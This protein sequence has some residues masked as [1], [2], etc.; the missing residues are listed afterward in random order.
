VAA[1]AAGSEPLVALIL[2]RP[3]ELGAAEQRTLQRA[4]VVAA[5]LLLRHRSVSDAEHRVR[6]ELLEEV[7]DAP[8]GDPESLRQRVRRF[9][10]DPDQPYVIVVADSPGADPERMDAAA[11]HIAE[12]RRGLAGRRDGYTVLALPGES[13]N[14][15]LRAVAA[16]LRAAAGGT[17]TAAGAGPTSGLA[18][19][20]GTHREAVRCLKALHALGRAGTTAVPGDLGFLGVLLGEHR[21]VGAFVTG[22]LGPLVEYDAER[23]TALVDT[24]A[25]YFGA[26]GSLTRAKDALHVH[27]NTVAQRLERIS[28]LI[29]A[30]WHEPHRALELQLALR[31]HDLLRHGVDLGDDL[32]GG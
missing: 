15:V 28:Q 7:L 12:I 24:L 31:V 27:V 21:D 22:T 20:P 4:G 2:R 16:D 19:F 18:S 5:L 6:G 3:S 30:D 14:D 32:G 9:A 26:G 17:V 25:A 8:R 29:G 23:G 10:T 11:R 13:P 1:A